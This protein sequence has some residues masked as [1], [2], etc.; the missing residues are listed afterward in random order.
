MVMS[1]AKVKNAFSD[2]RLGIKDHNPGVKLLHRSSLK[3]VFDSGDAM[4]EGFS[5]KTLTQS[6]SLDF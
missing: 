5:E 2:I 1:R 3:A 4:V 6:V